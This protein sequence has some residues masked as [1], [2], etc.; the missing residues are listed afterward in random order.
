MSEVKPFHYTTLAAA[1][2]V[3]ASATSAL[4]SLAAPLCAMAMARRF[5][6]GAAQ[7]GKLGV[8]MGA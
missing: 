3:I 4:R 7:C 6:G 8:R 2:G 5:G 1:K